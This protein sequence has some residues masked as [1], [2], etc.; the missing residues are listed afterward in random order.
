MLP[1]S[2]HDT[3]N[4]DRILP[5]VGL[6]WLAGAGGSLRSPIRLREYGHFLLALSIAVVRVGLGAGSSQ[7][8]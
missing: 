2:L 1:A 5:D 8:S 7:Q 3:P 4:E 6:G